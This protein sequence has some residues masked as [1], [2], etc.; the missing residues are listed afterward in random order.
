MTL[1]LRYLF[2]WGCACPSSPDY[3][4]SEGKD[5]KFRRPRDESENADAKASRRMLF[6]ENI[7]ELAQSVRPV[8]SGSGSGV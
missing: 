5:S 4:G 2:V 8:A 1:T 3:A 7:I 6:G